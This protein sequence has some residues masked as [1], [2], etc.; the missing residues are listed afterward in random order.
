MNRFENI[1]IATDL[2]GT[3]LD[4]DKRLVARNL[5]AVRY[6]TDNGGHFTVST[7]RIP[8]HVTAGFKSVREYIN[9]P[10]VTCNGACIY[11]FRTEERLKLYTVPFEHIKAVT[12]LVHAEYPGAAIRAS[13]WEHG[14]LCTPA[15]MNNKFIKVDFERNAIVSRL[16][17]D[18]DGWS[19]LSLFKIVIRADECMAEVILDRLRAL[20]GDLFSITQSDSTILDLQ[21][22]G[23]DKGIALRE[24][25]SEM[26]EG[27]RLYTCGDYINDL[28]MH[29]AADVSVCP[30]NAHPTVIE[31]CD[32]CLR[33][34][35]DGLIADLVEYLDRESK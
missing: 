33:T 26:G 6:F 25:V 30:S 28:E 29:R 20:F 24:L 8:P 23:R 21:R 34:N 11:D 14:F 7:G 2:D 15:D 9:M 4:S 10:A 16:V 12:D 32:L 17:C 5:E 35:D 19:D 3:F 27:M 18:V 22:R 31:E 1:V 13:S